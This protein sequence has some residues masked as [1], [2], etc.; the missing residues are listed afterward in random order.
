MKAL[1]VLTPKPDSSK[2]EPTQFGWWLKEKNGREVQF[3][4]VDQWQG[5]CSMNSFSELK[6]TSTFAIGRLKF[7]ANINCHP[8]KKSV[9]KQA[10]DEMTFLASG[11]PVTCHAIR[12]TF[13][14]V[15]ASKSEFWS[16]FK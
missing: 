7:S 4:G 9:V 5:T 16:E 10:V 8:Y 2:V 3:A 11:T 14:L 13:E 15:T 1:M 12:I 6:S